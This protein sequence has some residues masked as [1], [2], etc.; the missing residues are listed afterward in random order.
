MFSDK[1]KLYK[2]HLKEL[3]PLFD[4]FEES[5]IISS[6]F[7]NKNIMNELLLWLKNRYNLE[8]YPYKI[9]CIDISHFSWD[10]TSGWLVS[11]RWWIVNKKYYRQYKINKATKSDD[12]AS[13]KELITRRF[14]NKDN[15][16]DLFVI[17]W[18]KWQL[19]VLKDILL[20]DPKFTEI[21]N[22]IDFVSLWKWEARKNSS[23]LKWAKEIIFKFDNNFDIIWKELIYDNIDRLLINLRDEAHRFS[24]KYRE[25]QMEKGFER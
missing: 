10:Y 20:S 7:E 11:M 23:K 16:P 3:I 9:E 1:T 5:Y 2:K 18:W 25:K 6:S 24:N 19:W 13:I 4:K 22:Q 15:L 21:Y 8:N 12:Y 14:K 17:D